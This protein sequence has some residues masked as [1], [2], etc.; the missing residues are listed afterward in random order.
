M[1]SVTGLSKEYFKKKEKFMAVDDLSFSV[2]K[3]ELVGFLGPNGAGKTTTVKMLCGLIVPDKGKIEIGGFNPWHD[4][5]KALK[6]ISAV[7]EGN[8][9]IY[10]PLTVKENMEFFAALHGISSRSIA[11]KIDELVEVLGLKDKINEAARNLSRG[12]QQKLALGVALI[13]DVPVIILDEPTL[14]LDVESAFEMREVLKKLV[15]QGKTILLTTHDMYLV[16][17]VCHR[18]IIINKGKIVTDENI[19][20]ILRLFQV[21]SYRISIK[22]A[23]SSSQKTELLNLK[24]ISIEQTDNATSI[25]VNLED[26]EILYLIM[27][28]LRCE[29]TL[30]EAINREDIDFQNV[31]MQ[32]V[33]GGRENE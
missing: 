5:K 12:M 9:N 6:N 7:L 11:G 28:I 26:T 23:L 24:H 30:I 27:D 8:R 16:E 14:G 4:R 17:A 18:V 2:G 32:I 20:N 1:I 19:E 25:Q 10:W 21:K 3:G 31:Y 33:K 22:G 13:K 15:L 29:K